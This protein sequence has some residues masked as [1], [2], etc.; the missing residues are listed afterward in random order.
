MKMPLIEQPGVLPRIPGGTRCLAGSQ[1]LGARHL[2]PLRATHAVELRT[3]RHIG[4]Q[5]GCNQPKPP[6]PFTFK[7][8]V[9][10]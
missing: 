2:Q 3:S 7:P 10:R 8:Q 1:I 9:V 4:Q 5:F 6:A